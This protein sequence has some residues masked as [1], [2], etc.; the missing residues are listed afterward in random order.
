MPDKPYQLMVGDTVIDL[1][2]PWQYKVG[3]A[4]AQPA[5]YADVLYVQTG[6]AF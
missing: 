2:G 1:K 6:R 4:T 3:A 5:A